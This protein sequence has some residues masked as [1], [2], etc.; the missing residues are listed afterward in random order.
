MKTFS[1]LL[2]VLFVFAARALAAL[3]ASQRL[4]DE[5]F[6]R[7]TGIETTAEGAL[8]RVPGTAIFRAPD[9]PLGWHRPT[10]YQEEHDGVLDLRAWYGLRFEVALDRDDAAFTLDLTLGLPPQKERHN[11]PDGASAHAVVQGSGWRTVTVPVESFDYN[12]GQVNFLKFIQTIALAGRYA[13]GAKGTA[14]LR[15]IRLVRGNVLHLAS[16]VRSHPGETGGSVDYAVTLTNCTETP[17]VVSLA[18][19]RSGWEAMPA[20]VTPA[21]LSLAAG[22]SATASVR[23]A[24]PS[25]IPPGARETQTLVATAQG[26]SA[27]PVKLEF[28]TLR[29]LPFPFLVHDAAGWAGVRA[30]A[31][32]YD[33]AK[34]E[35][36]DAIA[37][38][39]A[40]VVPEPFPHNRAPDGTRAVFKSYIESELSRCALAY[41]LTGENKYAEKLALFLRRLSSPENGYPRTRHA[42]SQGIPQEGG[43][44]R[45]CVEAYDAIH[46]SGLLTA[47]DQRQIEQ[48]F[49][50]YIGVVEDMMGD[51]GI[52]NWS[53]FNLIPAAMC[54]LA[55]QDLAHFQQLMEG[56]CG[57]IDHVRYGVMSDGWWYEMSLSYNLGCAEEFTRLGLAA[58]PFGID[59]LD[60]KIPV[61]LTTK[62]GL[63]PFEFE[64]FLGMA[65][66]KYGP[67]PK[68]TVTIK[69]LWDGIVSYPDYRGV[70]FGMGDGHEQVVSGGP[71]EL[72]Y[73]AFRDP[74][75][76]TIVQRGGHRDLVYGVP[77]L[78][79]ETP[80]V[81]RVSG[82]SDNAGVAVLR[83]QTAGREPREQIQ[84]AFKYGT[85]G[86]YHGHF[87][88]LSLLSLMRYGRSF[89]N[90][91]TSW[92]GYGSYMYKW[93]V[94]PSLAHNMVVVDAKQQEPQSSRSLLFHSGALM[95]VTA[96]ENISRWSNPPYFGDYEQW[97]KVKSGDAP[98]VAIPAGHP[99]PGDVT[100]FTEPVRGQ[101]I[102]NVDRYAGAAPVL[103]QSVHR[104]GDGK[105]WETGGQ[106]SHSEPGDLH[107]DVRVLWPQK[108]EIA[109]GDFPENWNIGKKLFYE[110]KGDD[111]SLAAG[112]FGAW[113]LG[114]ADIDVD[115]RGVKTLRL[116]TQAK[117]PAN[118]RNTLFWGAPMIVTAEGKTLPL[119]QLKPVFNNV[120]TAPAPG[121]DYEGGPVRIAGLGYDDVLGAEPK[122]DHEAGLISVDLAGVNAVRFQASVGGDWPVGDEEQLRKTVA[123][124]ARG[125]TARFLT[126]I[127]PYEKNSL[128]KSARATGP[129]ALRVE[130][131]DGRVQEISIVAF[132]DDEKPVAVHLTETKDGRVVRSESTVP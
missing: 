80:A 90:P 115:V 69:Q 14:R 8:L 125:V 132:A 46:D 78:P 128:V 68:T 89:Y 54:A 37:R 107:L 55:V 98:F 52:S 17:Q 12:R 114:R 4:D 73:H 95:Q 79:A 9:G 40:W 104:F 23:V 39:D 16:E 38:A 57:I 121:R 24:I 10:D 50:L 126:L 28:T 19:Q 131:A 74:A 124:R 117:R 103:V 2:V 70:M 82:H 130:L 36:A 94:Q 11:F 100:D 5:K 27:E 113:N 58:R 118:G 47:A 75:Y 63:R 41:R 56:P 84:V 61:A 86:S 71:F 119:A 1:A 120:I 25:G 44:F 83:S 99:K 29:R 45:G 18:L 67:L 15:N 116:S 66:G 62:V 108:P 106:K 85:H 13:D 32:K 31:A 34:K 93:W 105:N 21:M 59:F 127:E 22:A 96:A 64:N 91:E 87:D 7:W 77:E 42:N 43:F 102:T 20:E 81:Y 101:F 129:D 60:R 6:Q 35:A 111:R 48:T 51:G 49:R 88:R 109:T 123:I 97:E 3:P 65:F 72:A 53:V 110:V 122:N 76:A 30:K 112:A 26:G 92:F 33:W